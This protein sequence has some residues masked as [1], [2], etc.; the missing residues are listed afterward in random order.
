MSRVKHL[1]LFDP[2]DEGTMTLCNTDIYL[3]LNTASLPSSAGVK[4]SN[5]TV[6][7]VIHTDCIVHCILKKSS[8][9]TGLDRPRGF[10]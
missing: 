2:E 6:I 4:T 1:E 9:I 3:P 8:P 5:L 7:A 10:Q